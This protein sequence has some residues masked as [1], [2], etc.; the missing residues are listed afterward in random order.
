MK[1]ILLVLLMMVLSGC[2]TANTNVG[3]RAW[4][5]QRIQ[6]IETAYKEGEITK[7]EY[8][9]LMNEADQVRATKKSSPPYNK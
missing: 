1:K 6:E 2:I 5:S 8:I 3:T 9:N 4:H 7:A